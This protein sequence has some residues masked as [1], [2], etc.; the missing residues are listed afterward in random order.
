MRFADTPA[1]PESD[2]REAWLAYAGELTEAGD[3]RGVA[4]WQEHRCVTG[5]GDPA[6]AYTEVERQL[7]LDGLRDDGSWQFTWSRG[8]IET[9][10]L[11]RPGG[12]ER[13]PRARQATAPAVAV[14]HGST[15]VYLRWQA[16]DRPD[17][18]AA[19]RAGRAA[20]TRTLD[21]LPASG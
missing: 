6:G 13:G 9:A 18:A 14:R 8:F 16:S 21:R 12:Y 5:G 10:R 19:L 17:P 7:G 15:M 20:L 4:I 2:D 11:Y 1:V 3:P